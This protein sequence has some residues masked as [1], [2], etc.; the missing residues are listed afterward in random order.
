M[1]KVLTRDLAFKRS[2]ILKQ[3]REDLIRGSMAQKLMVLYRVSN[4]YFG[5]DEEFS[6]PEMAV[7]KCLEM[8][9]GSIAAVERGD[10]ND[11]FG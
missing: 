11:S 8:I 4:F 3:M 10:L 6:V 2:V 1:S 9:D 7:S 5:K